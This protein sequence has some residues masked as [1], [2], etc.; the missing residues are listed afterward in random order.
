MENFTVNITLFSACKAK[1]RKR[2]MFMLVII[3]KI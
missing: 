1:S 3:G 2:V